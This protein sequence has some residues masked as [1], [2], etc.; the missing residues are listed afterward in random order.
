[1]R[2]YKK[3]LCLLL[4]FVNTSQSSAQQ[5]SYQ[6]GD[7]NLNQL[8]FQDESYWIEY[9]EEIYEGFENGVYWFKI[10]FG[11]NRKN[12][13]LFIPESHITRASLF[14]NQTEVPSSSSNRFVT[15]KLSGETTF[16]LRVDCKLE[17]RIPLII[18]PEK[19]FVNHENN[20]FLVMGVYYGIVLSIMFVNLFSYFSFKDSTYLHYVLMVFGMAA[21]AFYKDGMFA[22]IF[23][24]SGLNEVIEP[25]INSIVPLSAILFVNS[26]LRARKYSPILYL[27]SSWTIIIAQVLVGL[28]IVS[29]V[30]M[31]LFTLTDVVLMI[32][33]NAFWITGAS[34]WKKSFEA[35]FFTVAYGLPLI[36]AHEFYVFPHFG[37]KFMNLGVNW[38][39]VGSVFEM[40]VFTYA[41]MYKTKR[42]KKENSEIRLKVIHYESELKAQRRDLNKEW[43]SKELREKYEFTLKEIDVLRDLSFGKTNKIIAKEHFISVNTVKTHIRNIFN[44]LEVNN[45]SD[46]GKHYQKLN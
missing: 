6:R 46:A 41:I 31:S 12:K 21:N 20:E 3:L 37:I 42:I 15:F 9:K 29:G 32:S 17:A 11:K 13:I 4:I 39:K 24:R 27:L 28:L 44:K 45:R 22:L 14:V 40:I 36:F 19:E 26:Y 16:Y 34:I 23:G 35:R 2:H 7:I 25:A 30:N 38:Y 33:I 8:K 43:I 18:M 1:M 5:I 10:S